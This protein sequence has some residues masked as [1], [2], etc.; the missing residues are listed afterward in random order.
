MAKTYV[1]ACGASFGTEAQLR[2]HAATC[3]VSRDPGGDP[4][5]EV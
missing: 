4:A 3:G 1:C 5:P 2:A